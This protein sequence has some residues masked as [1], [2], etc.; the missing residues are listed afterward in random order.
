MNFPE[1]Y[2]G[3]G[4]KEISKQVQ[5]RVNT[6]VTKLNMFGHTPKCIAPGPTGEMSVEFDLGTGQREYIFYPDKTRVVIF[7]TDG[8]PPIQI[9]I[10]IK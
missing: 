9:D 3:M 2:D 6:F 10:E 1:N 4:A 8:S 5:Q 7:P